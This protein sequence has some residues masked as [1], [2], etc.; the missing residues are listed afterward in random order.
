METMA[1]YLRWYNDRDVKPLVEA[2]EKLTAMWHNKD[3]IS[4]FTGGISLPGV[5]LTSLFHWLWTRT[6]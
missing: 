4:L 6:P 2:L 1:N 5:T 3:D